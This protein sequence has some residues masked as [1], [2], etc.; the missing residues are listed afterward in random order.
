MT[1]AG[2]ADFTPGFVVEEVEGVEDDDRD[3]HGRDG[4]QQPL[5]RTA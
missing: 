5:S 3:K 1:V 2:V 4:V